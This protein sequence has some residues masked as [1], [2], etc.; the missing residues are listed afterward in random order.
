MNTTLTIDLPEVA[1]FDSQELKLKVIAYVKQLAIRKNPEKKE[2]RAP[3][4]WRDMAI[5]PEV[6]AMTFENRVDLGTTDYKIL[7]QEALEEKYK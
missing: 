3:G 7:L 5:S 2:T 6:E 1:L 4:S